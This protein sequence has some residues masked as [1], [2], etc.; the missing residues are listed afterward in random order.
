MET[1]RGRIFLGAYAG[2]DA[3]NGDLHGVTGCEDKV[4][5]KVGDKET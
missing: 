2:K 3:E 5:D 4:A 1:R